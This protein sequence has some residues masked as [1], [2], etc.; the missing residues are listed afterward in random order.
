MFYRLK[1]FLTSDAF[2]PNLRIEL[3]KSNPEYIK[4][5]ERRMKDM[6]KC[7]HGIVIAGMIQHAL[8]R[9]DLSKLLMKLKVMIQRLNTFR[10]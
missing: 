10:L 4:N 2:E 9:A 8:S 1:Q 6:A 3:A 5:I 7:D